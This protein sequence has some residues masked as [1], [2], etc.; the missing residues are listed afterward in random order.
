MM[1]FF[2]N[3]QLAAGYPS[4]NIFGPEGL[5]PQTAREPG[6][7][8]YVILIPI[9]NVSA[10]NIE[11]DFSQVVFSEMYTNPAAFDYHI[12]NVNASLDLTASNWFL[13]LGSTSAA[14]FAV[15]SF[16]S[17]CYRCASG[18]LL[19]GT[20]PPPP[21]PTVDGV[22]SAR[23]GLGPDFDAGYGF[24]HDVIHNR[25]VVGSMTTGKIAGFA[26]PTSTSLVSVGEAELH[27]YY[28]GGATAAD[29][30]DL[31]AATGLWVD[32][33]QPCKLIVAVGSVS[34]SVRASRRATNATEGAI[35]TVSLCGGGLIAYTDLTPWAKANGMWAN[36]LVQVGT[37]LWLTDNAGGQVLKIERHGESAGAIVSKAFDLSH[38]NG[39]A[40]TGDGSLLV[41]SL[42]YP[43]GF[44]SQ[45]YKFNPTTGVG[46]FVRGDAPHLRGGGLKT[47]SRVGNR[48]T[49]FVA[50]LFQLRAAANTFS[51]VNTDASSPYYNSV[52]VVRS[53]DSWASS[54][55]L[56]NLNT[57]CPTMPTAP[58]LVG[59]DLYV[60]CLRTSDVSP[61]NTI[62]RFPRVLSSAPPEPS[63]IPIAAPDMPPPPPPPPPPKCDT[64]PRQP[65]PPPP[66]AASDSCGSVGDGRGIT[67]AAIVVAC[68]SLVGNA[69]LLWYV[70][71]MRAQRTRP[72]LAKP[73]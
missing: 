48:S 12:L 40:A 65:Q 60:L 1:G 19:D 36:D 26:L 14:Y 30:R 4:E 73:A 54:Q 64:E 37:T 10:S 50:N 29:G 62:V 33:A 23:L 2:Y 7:N 18:L 47:Y 5:G 71:W 45:L 24:A 27:T 66:F 58:V 17:G 70:W 67:V 21:P 51:R 52:S 55:T 31:F 56:L 49:L 20:L 69:C 11:F 35:A 43:Y 39:I 61:T 22:V 16:S 72:L 3:D 15:E 9:S 42:V 46:G 41:S 57:H 63:C 13:D 59:D 8:D 34:P 28:A 68:L 25:L 32:E 6:T 53:V 44:R 38:A